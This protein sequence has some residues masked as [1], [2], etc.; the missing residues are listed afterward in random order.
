MVIHLRKLISCLAA[1]SP[2]SVGSVVKIKNYTTELTENTERGEIAASALG[3][4]L[5]I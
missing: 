1:I 2:L 4:S 3:F 5:V